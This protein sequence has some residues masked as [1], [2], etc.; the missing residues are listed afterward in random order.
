M[1]ILGDSNLLWGAFLFLIQRDHFLSFKL[2]LKRTRA[3]LFSFAHKI[4]NRTP[5][6]SQ[7]GIL[8]GARNAIMTPEEKNSIHFSRKVG[9]LALS[10]T[11]FLMISKPL[12]EV[13][14]V[15]VTSQLYLASLSREN[16]VFKSNLVFWCSW[17]ESNFCIRFCIIAFKLME[18]IFIVFRLYFLQG[19]CWC[20]KF[21]QTNTSWNSSELSSNLMQRS[22]WLISQ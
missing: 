3:I 15:W 10:F 19:V 4:G 7:R 8:S 21:W 11:W 20:L 18:T 17:L 22:E 13:K 2:S 12:L 5:S 14:S 6:Y 16:I 1:L 9:V